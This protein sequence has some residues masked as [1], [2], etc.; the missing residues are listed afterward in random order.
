MSVVTSR[1]PSMSGTSCSCAGVSCASLCARRARST[2]KMMSK[3]GTFFSIRLHS[4]TRRAPSRSSDSGLIETR[5]SWSSGR[6]SASKL[7]VP[8]VQVKR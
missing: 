7:N 5:T 3:L 4:S 1:R 8:C 2:S 6:M